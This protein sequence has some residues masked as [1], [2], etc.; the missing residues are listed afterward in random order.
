MAVDLL[1]PLPESPQKNSYV[2]VVGDYFS[3]WME[4]IPLP[5]QEAATVACHL[6]DEVFMRF[7]VPE[8]LHSDQGRQF[9]SQLISEVC[10]ALH[11]KKTRTTPYHPQCDGLVERFNRTLLNML[12]TH[13]T[14]HPWDWE[15]HIRK[16]CMAYNTS[17]NATTG[18][19]PFYLMFGRQ[20]RLPVDVMYGNT[21]TDSQSPSEYAV[22]LKKQLTA[23]YETVRNT[24]KSQHERQKELYDRKIPGD[25]YMAGDWVW[26]L[27]P[28]V[29]KNSTRKL[30]HPWQGPYKIVKKIS[31][32]VYRIQALNGAR[33][34]QVVHFNRLKPCPK[35]PRLLQL[36]NSGDEIAKDD[37]ANSEEPSAPMPVGTNLQLIDEDCNDDPCPRT[38]CVIK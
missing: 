35:D 14:D 25:P 18:Y 34:R 16:V 27:N 9:E 1:G 2:M 19:T 38:C 26:V 29:P 10:K 28:K 31:E 15:Q 3:R 22:N 13:C 11:I 21:P 17:V 8:Q 23:A 32:C 7:S 6:I 24:C 4:A 12:A 33:R 5:N 30:F 37:V 20:A 36:T